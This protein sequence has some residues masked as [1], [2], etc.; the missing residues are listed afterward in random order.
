LSALVLI[1]GL[2]L[3][4]RSRKR[5]FLFGG[6]FVLTAA[7]VYGLLIVLWHR[8]FSLLA[9]Y[10]RLLEIL[11]ALVSVSGSAF[12]FRQFLLFKK[13][14]PHCSATAGNSFTSRSFKK[15]QKVFERHDGIWILLGG[16]FLFSLVVTVVEFPCSA[17]IPVIFAG[18]LAKA[19]LSFAAFFFYLAVF[20]LFYMLDEF[21]VF[22]IAVFK[23]N[24]WFSSHK[25]TIWATLV[26]A[27][28]LAFIGL[29]Y[30]VGLV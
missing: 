25:F 19:N 10:I 21:V 29:Y 26:E 15:I 3:V 2:V 20:V 7:V 8:F 14:G 12:F 6:M 11:L 4:L 16:V 24:I 30:I 9:P 22:L 18:I 13:Y 17:A 28:I 27:F 23:M 1:L 5:I